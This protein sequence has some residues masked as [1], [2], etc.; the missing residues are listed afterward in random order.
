[1]S[2]TLAQ[3]TPAH[4]QFAILYTRQPSTL[5]TR[6]GRIKTNRQALLD[7]SRVNSYSDLARTTDNTKSA[8]IRLTNI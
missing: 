4:S 7:A 1:M 5:V 6:M 3:R 8:R 2:L